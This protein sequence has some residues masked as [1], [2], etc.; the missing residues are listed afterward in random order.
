MSIVLR[1]EKLLN[2][3][4]QQHAEYL[5]HRLPSGDARL[6]TLARELAKAGFLVI[7]AEVAEAHRATAAADINDW[8][9]AYARLYY[10]LTRAL[11]PPALLRLNAVYADNLYPPVV[12][13][14]GLC[15]PVLLA[16]ADYIAPYVAIRY[17]EPLNPIELNGLI[18]YV[19]DDLEAS[20][21][22]P[23]RRRQLVEACLSDVRALLTGRIRPRTLTSFART[24][25]E[26]LQ[27]PAQPARLLDTP[28]PP[29]AERF[30]KTGPL[31]TS[32]IP[33]FFEPKQ[34]DDG[35]S[36]PPK[37]PP[38]PLPER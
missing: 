9:N 4:A 5:L 6:P 30:G 32:D 11:F 1:L 25:S 3:L 23:V 27:P 14:E 15:A 18:H 8:V 20:N 17:G 10:T 29:P 31:F 28:P 12:V 24:L 2:A 33:I 21:L 19:L 13:L 22:Q 16:F 37:P 34:G 35:Q 38:P 36:R 26:Q 7:W